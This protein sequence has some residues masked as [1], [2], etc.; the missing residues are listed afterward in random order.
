[1]W[2]LIPKLPESNEFDENSIPQF[3]I[4]DFLLGKIIF[5]I[6]DAKYPR[7]KSP[8]KPDL[9]TYMPLK[10]IAVGNPFSG[11]KSLANYL[12]T[13]YGLEI[14][15]VSEI[16]KEAVDFASSAAPLEEQK[17]KAVKKPG[18]PGVK[19][20]EHIRIDN[21][22]LKILSSEMKE[23]V[24]QG[25]EIPTTL[26]IRGI[27]L[28]IKTL[29]PLKKEQEIAEE[30]KLLKQ[31]KEI[32]VEGKL[33]PPKIEDPKKKSGKSPVK[34]KIQEIKETK[35]G[36]SSNTGNKEGGFEILK[37]QKSFYYTKG[38]ILI[39]FPNDFAQVK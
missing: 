39:G 2:T 36:L 29:F 26:I 32:N 9:P 4:Q 38:W 25:K 18:K 10:L 34:S 8:E 15:S 30:L 21:P 16:I 27:I 17:N 19:I 3:P 20:D 13:K 35:E 12:K 1:M 24:S 33:D 28:K 37:S 7:L 6:I 11:R 22:E 23:Y 14:I 31:I 5:N